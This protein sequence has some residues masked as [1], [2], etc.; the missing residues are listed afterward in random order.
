[1][2]Q[3]KYQ[4]DGDARTSGPGF[5]LTL[6][7]DA[8]RSPYGWPGHRVVFVN[9]M[10][11]LS[12]RVK[13]PILKFPQIR[14]CASPSLRPRHVSRTQG[15]GSGGACTDLRWSS[16]SA[17]GRPQDQREA[18]GDRKNQEAEVDGPLPV[19]KRFAAHGRQL[20]YEPIQ[21]VHA[22]LLVV[23]HCSLPSAVTDGVRQSVV[24]LPPPHR[25]RTGRAYPAGSAA[26]AQ[27]QLDACMYRPRP[28][29][30]N[31]LPNPPHAP[32]RKGTVVSAGSVG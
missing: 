1:M 29:R 31:R 4:A 13:C 5:G 18:A 6:H 14:A 2:G 28:R 21:P 22:V 7:E 3:A 12:V 15:S 11:D 10:S 30:R 26:G 23:T 32:R 9:S 17:A 8:L 20:D 25:G 24:L 19:A 16:G 27:K